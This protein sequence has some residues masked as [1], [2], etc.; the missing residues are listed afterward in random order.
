MYFLKSYKP[1]AAFYIIKMESLASKYNFKLMR[2]L[3][4]PFAISSLFCASFFHSENTMAQKKKEELFSNQWAV[5]AKEIDGKLNDW[6]DSLTYYNE[7][8][9]FSY[10]IVNDDKMLYVAIKSSNHADFS[11]IFAGGISFMI[12]TEGKKKPG[13]TIIFPV[14]ERQHS[15]PQASR[16]TPGGDETDIRQ[17]MQQKMLERV[18]SIGV[19]GFKEILDGQISLYNTY[20]IK[21]AAAFTANND[22][23]VE[24]A[25]P[26]RLLDI[27]ADS[28]NILAYNIKINGLVNPMARNNQYTP[29]MGGAMGRP[30]AMGTGRFPNID[31][32][33]VFTSTDFWLRSSLAQKR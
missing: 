2:T 29:S 20:G 5:N 14:A 32:N 1:L 22:L 16:P 8:T 25:L 26:I 28:P 24:L 17:E 12:N 4:L 18:K 7:A 23:V 30:P 33:K 15:R 19:S 3:I 31:R 21:A 13:P 9:H 6:G 10:S 11:R 27:Q